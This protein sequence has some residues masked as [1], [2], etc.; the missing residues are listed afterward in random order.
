MRPVP[1]RINRKIAVAA[2]AALI[3]GGT[4]AANASASPAA[5]ST[6][7]TAP[8]L[9]KD[10]QTFADAAAKNPPI[11]AL[12]Y[13]DARKALDSAQASPVDKLPAR[14]GEARICLRSLALGA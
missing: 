4:L 10:A 1:V 7:T 3:A 5:S 12:S 9:E 14:S 11:Y 8:V 13:G 2:A 6:A